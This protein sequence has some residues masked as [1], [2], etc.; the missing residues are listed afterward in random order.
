MSTL[1]RISLVI[2]SVFTLWYIIRKIRKSQ[3]ITKDAS[4]WVL[5]SAA[6]I[7]F[8]V[9]PSI[10]IYTADLFGI[11]SPVNGIFLIII[12]I[13]L[14]KVF[15]LSIKVSKLDSKLTVLTEEIALKEKERENGN[16]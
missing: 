11:Q 8:A 12:F 15:L 4:F 5:F 16:S 1:L 10:V 6:L 14:I 13:L 2:V 9:F 7:L 3:M